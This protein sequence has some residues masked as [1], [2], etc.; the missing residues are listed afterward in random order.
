MK[1]YLYKI[2]IISVL[3][4]FILQSCSDKPKGEGDERVVGLWKFVERI[5]SQSVDNEDPENTEEDEPKLFPFNNIQGYEFFSDGS[6]D[7]KAGYFM[8]DPTNT[9]NEVY[10]GTNTNYS[11]KNDTLRI[12]NLATGLWD[13]YK[14]SLITKDTLEFQYDDNV[15]ERFARVEKNTEN[16]P[17]FDKIVLSTTACHGTCPINDI[18]IGKDGL[19][20]F[21]GT[22]YNVNNGLYKAELDTSYFNQIERAFQTANIDKLQEAYLPPVTD[23][24]TIEV[25]FIKDGKVYKNISDKGHSSP[26]EFQWAYKALQLMQQQV[27][28]NKYKPKNDFLKS[29]T[30]SISKG[31]DRLTLNK[32]ET[33]YLKYLLAEGKEM[34]IPFVKMY[35]FNVT[36]SSGQII[37]ASSDG[38]Y[39]TIGNKTYDIGY[40]F[41]NTLRS[42]FVPKED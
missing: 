31:K 41:I 33:A 10:L 5:D 2:L 32:A 27:M 16:Q 1:S 42:R 18:I 9:G 19:F 15:F 8:E 25:L 34:K 30:I 6:C 12:F 22:K 38:R 29:E 4:L 20:F 21:N 26:A 7:N 36:A 37:T 39:F 14:L 13:S 11:V 28:L 3:F 17:T 40:N 24:Q 23:L 35:V